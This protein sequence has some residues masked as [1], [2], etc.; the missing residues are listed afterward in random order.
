MEAEEQRHSLR[1]RLQSQFPLKFVETPHGLAAVRDFIPEEPVREED[2]P[3]ITMVG[4]GMNQKDIGSAEAG[5]H[6]LGQHTITVDIEGEGEGIENADGRSPE[7]V[8]Q[9]E[10][11]FEILEGLPQER[12]FLLGQSISSLV[13]DTVLDMHPE[14]TPRVAGYIS[15]SGM[16]KGGKDNVAK[17]A[18]RQFQ[19]GVRA[20]LPKNENGKVKYYDDVKRFLNGR[21][22]SRH[23]HP[24]NKEEVT[25]R[26]LS[27]ELPNDFYGM[28][29]GHV[30]NN[31]G[32]A[33][34]E[35]I[36]MAQAD[37]YEALKRI[38]AQ[39]VQVGLIQ[40]EE[41]MLNSTNR[42][43]DRIG[44]GTESA[45]KK[46][47]LKDYLGDPKYRD[48]KIRAGSKIWNRDTENEAPPYDYIL[49]VGGGHETYARDEMPKKIIRMADQM[50]AKTNTV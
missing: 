17:L 23:I 16:G 39:G 44:Q 22:W 15:M 32:R 33:K 50:L 4:F 37:E 35:I 11:L 28:M 42:V 5:L 21:S 14:L 30:W 36:A 43:W 47:G 7:I 20:V 25:K 34:E 13:M 2:I 19:E 46:L 18:G 10:I 48:K 49:M 40:G 1:E 9:A 38:K 8:R 45:W 26:D 27:D 24:A 31:K 6:A 12:F 3:M 29:G 41:D